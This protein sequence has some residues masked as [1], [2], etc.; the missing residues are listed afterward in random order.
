MSNIT[1]LPIYHLEKIINLLYGCEP[2]K[3]ILFLIL[4][5]LI[6]L[7]CEA[8]KLDISFMGG[9]SFSNISNDNN[10]RINQ[11]MVNEYK[12]N[13]HFQTQ[14]LVGVGFAHTFDNFSQPINIS[15]G[16][17]SYYVDLGKVKGIEHPFINDGIYDS[18]NYQ[19]NIRSFSA[20]L[21]SR[22]I[23]TF[24]DW[25]PYALIGAGAA[26]NRFYSYSETPTIPSESAAASPY[27]FSNHTN[28]SFSYELGVGFQKQIYADKKHQLNYLLSLDYRYLN[29]GKGNLGPSS[30]QT[31]NNGIQVSNLDMQA[32]MLSFKISV[33]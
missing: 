3:W 8:N 21:E 22:L 25:Q 32:I 23:Y 16:L 27:P 11:Y 30:V 29:F 14:P 10:V 4:M 15:F 18:L 6:P 20:M 1:K 2:M 33:Q 24:Y 17:S 13:S 26:W 7:A 5:L 12:T 9:P 31:S 19:F 28:A